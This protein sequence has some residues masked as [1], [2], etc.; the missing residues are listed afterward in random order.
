MPCA[1]FS[2]ETTRSRRSLKTCARG[3]RKSCGPLSASTEAHWLIELAFDVVCDCNFVIA[4]I[5]ALL[6]VCGTFLFVWRDM[7]VIKSE[8]VHIRQDVALIQT[9]I[10]NDDPKAFIAAKAGI[11]AELKKDEATGE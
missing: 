7:A 8:M 2:I 6:G 11:H 4:L 9:F 3:L 1:W 10:A 5:S